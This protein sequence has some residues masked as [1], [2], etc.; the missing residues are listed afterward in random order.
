MAVFLFGGLAIDKA[1]HG[2]H[3]LFA[4]GVRVVETFDTTRKSVHV[5]S[6]LQGNEYSL[7]AAFG[8]YQL[9]AFLLL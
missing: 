4:L 6:L 5:Q 1:D 9:L 7:V 8:I 3:R 2:G